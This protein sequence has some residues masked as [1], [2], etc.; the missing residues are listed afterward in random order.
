MGAAD[1]KLV[2]PE[3]RQP[4]APGPHVDRSLLQPGV[5][6]LRPPPQPPATGLLARGD[7][8]YLKDLNAALEA[9]GTPSSTAIIYLIAL[10]IIAAVS[11][12]A[13]AKV[14]RSR[15]PRRGSCRPV[16]SR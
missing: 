3:V 11:W 15:V 12:A 4:T 16:T 7:A 8:D 10:F 5:T 2:G 14:E 13:F 1:P 9:Q 6:D